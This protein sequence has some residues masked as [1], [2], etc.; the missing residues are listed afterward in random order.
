MIRLSDV[1]DRESLIILW[2]EAFGDSREAVEI[3]LDKR[4][5]TQNTLV[6]DVDGKIAS[7]LFLLEG[8]IKAKDKIL[9]AYYLYAAATLK[10][11]RGK[12]IM[13]QMLCEAEKLAQSRGI[14]L[15]CLKPAEK[16]LYGFYKKHGY[17]TVFA[18]KNV[19][20]KADL[21]ASSVFNGNCSDVFSA[22]ESVFADTDR[23]IWNKSA[24][25]FAISQHKYYGGKVF[26][27][28]EG[29]CLYSMN[30]NACSVKEFCFTSQNAMPV[31]SHIA[32]LEHISEFRI[33]LP[34]GYP[35]N[36][37][38]VFVADNGMALFIS[39]DSLVLENT[40]DLYLNLT[41]D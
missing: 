30:D 40:K 3:F 2:Q 8:K 14:D 7:M 6:A 19:S 15:I 12:G 5:L 28:R 38:S 24:I 22:R 9:K 23:F 29:Y 16:S 25:E 34:V 39:K 32:A 27:T 21:N 4:C 37:D 1:T 35:F 11:F 36:S 33:E 10:E 41:L 20:V 13:A 17:K 18:T 31:L 26:E